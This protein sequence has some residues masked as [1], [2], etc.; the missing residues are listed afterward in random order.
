MT[1]HTRPAVAH[2]ITE[3][4][5][6]QDQTLW[7]NCN[8]KCERTN[9]MWQLAWGRGAGSALPPES[10]CDRKLP[11]A[12]EKL[13]V[14][15]HKTQHRTRPRGID[16]HIRNMMI[17][18]SHAEPVIGLDISPLSTGDSIFCTTNF[19]VRAGGDESTNPLLMMTSHTEAAVQQQAYFS[20][21]IHLLSL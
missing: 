11:P 8:N 12:G 6:P 19:R 17:M 15:K 7:S 18:M 3:H 9:P 5:I 21:S 2:S 13:C 1:M 16:T 10:H 14:T 20:Y 4:Y